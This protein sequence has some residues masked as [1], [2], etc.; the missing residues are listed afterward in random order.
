[1]NVDL[2]FLKNA[3]LIFAT[4]KTVLRDYLTLRGHSNGRAMAPIGRD[5][6]M[7]KS[8]Y[9]NELLPRLLIQTKPTSRRF[10]CWLQ[11]IW[12]SQVAGPAREV[13]VVLVHMS[14]HHVLLMGMTKALIYSKRTNLQMYF[15]WTN[16][17]YRRSIFRFKHESSHRKCNDTHIESMELDHETDV[18]DRTRSIHRQSKKWMNK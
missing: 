1:M 8:Y 5:K 13:L 18:T 15:F 10:I 7:L 4:E 6:H 2:G 3:G 9:L 12:I 11:W 17:N 14:N 16:I